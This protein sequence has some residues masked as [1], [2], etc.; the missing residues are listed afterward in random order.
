[1]RLV[2]DDQDLTKTRRDDR[3]L[4][5]VRS[6]LQDLRGC[7]RH[8]KLATKGLRSARLERTPFATERWLQAEREASY[9]CGGVTRVMKAAVA[10]TSE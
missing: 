7:G 6:P 2:R 9:V 4:F 5:D 8:G 10:E 3:A 1:M